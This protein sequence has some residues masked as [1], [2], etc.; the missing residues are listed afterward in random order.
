LLA[1]L[2]WFVINADGQVTLGAVPPIGCAAIAHDGQHTRIALKLQTDENQMRLLLRF[3]EALVRALEHDTSLTKST[4][5][6]DRTSKPYPC[7][8][9]TL[10]A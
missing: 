7:L 6:T 3:D 4:L 9:R 2:E 1:T 8:R 5:R 10:T